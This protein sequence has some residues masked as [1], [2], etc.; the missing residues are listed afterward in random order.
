MSSRH[1]G[2]LWGE[3]GKYRKVFVGDAEEDQNGVANH[4]RVEGRVGGN[5]RQRK[6]AASGVQGTSVEKV[7]ERLKYGSMVSISQ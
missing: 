5:M 4:L 7:F 1:V 6:L 2:G 3:G